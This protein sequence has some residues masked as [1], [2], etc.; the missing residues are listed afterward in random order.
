M[1]VSSF[2]VK[3]IIRVYDR[4]LTNG[5]K[6]ARLQK[7]IQESGQGD[8]VSISREAKRRQMVERVAKE[9]VDNLITSGSNSPIVQEIKK[10]LE[11]EF[12]QEFTFHYPPSGE[13]LQI[14]RQSPEGLTELRPDEK[15]AVLNKLWEITLN[16][17]NET[18]L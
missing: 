9:I 1:N 5:R 15:K 3:N 12:N 14:F 16:K 2:L 4:Q 10:E 17:V 8:S 6:L 7:Y 11:K 18:M 13:E